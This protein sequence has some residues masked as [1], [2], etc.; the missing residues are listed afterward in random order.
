MTIYTE[1]EYYDEVMVE[2]GSPA[3]LK[4]EDSGW[5]P[6]YEEAAGWIGYNEDVVDLGCG[7]GRFGALLQGRGHY[8]GYVGLDF[9]VSAL[10]EAQRYLDQRRDMQ[11]L[12]MVYELKQQDLRQWEPSPTR[13]GNCVY[14]CLETLEHL[15]DDVGLIRRIPPGH[16]FIFSVPNY[17]SDAH[18]R[19]F[20]DV[21]ALWKRY[22]KLLE[23]RRWSLVDLGG[24]AWLVHVVE[25]RR[26]GDSW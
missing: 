22:D 4:L 8:G 23:F 17:D 20:R 21:G 1:P 19:T 26:R 10:S 14:T 13:A 7:T 12:E 3:M 5:L 11:K 2:K 6:L 18:L 25:T 9:S 24:P 16:R 15:A